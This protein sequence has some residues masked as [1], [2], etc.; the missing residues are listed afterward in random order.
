MPAD[1]GQRLPIKRAER[2]DRELSDV[3]ALQDEITESVLAAIEPEWFVVEGRRAARKNPAYLDAYDLFMR[4]MW[5]YYQFNPED[6]RRAEECMR[7]A[8]ALDPHLAQGHFGL[9][10]SAHW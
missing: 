10:A 9:A 7:K 8:V 4:G 2:Y 3:F 1:L 5:H 6:N